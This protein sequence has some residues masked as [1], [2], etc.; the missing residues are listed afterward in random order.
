M[1]IV[2]WNGYTMLSEFRYIVNYLYATILI[3]V[4]TFLV[5]YILSKKGKIKLPLYTT[6]LLS[7]LVTILLFFALVYL[8][9]YHVI[10]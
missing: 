7:L 4:L 5:L 10:V 3:G 6:V 1:K 8:F 9:P 2:G